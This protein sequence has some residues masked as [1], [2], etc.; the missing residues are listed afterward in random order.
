MLMLSA[1]ACAWIWKQTILFYKLNK[2]I[3]YINKQEKG[4]YVSLVV[5][6]LLFITLTNR[7]AFSRSQSLQMMSGDLPPSSRDTFFRLLLAQLEIYGRKMIIFIASE[8]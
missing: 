6:L 8:H 1:N 2:P 5:H 7:M 3:S 4:N